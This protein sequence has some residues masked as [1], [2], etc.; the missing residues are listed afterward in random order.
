MNINLDDKERAKLIPQ[1]KED[2]TANK[3][4]KNDDHFTGNLVIGNNIEDIS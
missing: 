3:N 1:I 2:P 4:L